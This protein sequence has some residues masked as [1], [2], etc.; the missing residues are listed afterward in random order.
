MKDAATYWNGMAKRYAGSKIKDEAAYQEKLSR[1]RAILTPQSRVAELGCGTGSTAIALAHSA[2]EIIAADISSEMLRIARE[3]ANSANINNIGFREGSLDDLDGPFDVFLCHS[4]FHLVPDPQ[5][6]IRAAA[7]QLKPGGYFVTS[8][9][10]LGDMGIGIR[11][12]AKLLVLF[13]VAPR[14]TWFTRNDLRGWLQDA[15]L[16]IVEDWQP[17]KNAALFLIGKKTS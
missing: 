15:G 17:K 1:T 3:K 8:S 14:L 12:F 13:G 11:L 5:A 4:F 9:S 6:V 2:G 16:E 10:C 7:L